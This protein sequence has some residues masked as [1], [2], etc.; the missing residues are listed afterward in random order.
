MAHA[1]GTAT[2]DDDSWLMCIQ[3]HISND[4]ESE[5][6]NV[7][8]HCNYWPKTLKAGTLQCYI[9]VNTTGEV[10]KTFTPRLYKID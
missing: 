1:V 3:A 5:G 10:D 8:G 7:F 9:F 6:V 4:D 2:V